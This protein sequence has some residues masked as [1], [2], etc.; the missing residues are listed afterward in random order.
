MP[1]SV[2]HPFEPLYAEDS[3]TLILGSFPSVRSRERNFYYGHPQNRFWRVIAA[4]YGEAVPATVPEKTAL[5]LGHG[6]AL[7]DVIQSC[8]ITGSSDASIR[9]V[10]PA[11]LR[12]VLDRCPIRRIFCNGQTAFRLYRRYG[13]PVTGREA[14]CLP[15]TS[16]A[17]ARCTLADLTAAW[18]VLKDGQTPGRSR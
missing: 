16:P 1:E 17:N 15:S 14:V 8:E 3:H 18:R 2:V 11:D 5:I 6:L 10:R 13:L 9:N 7:W 4:L 12:R